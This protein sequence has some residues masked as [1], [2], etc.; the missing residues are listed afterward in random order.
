M[1]RTSVQSSV[2]CAKHHSAVGWSGGGEPLAYSIE[3]AAATVG[4]SRTSIKQEIAAGRLR[5][6]K[7]GRRTLVRHIDLLRWL[8][9]LPEAE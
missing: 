3:N 2:W 5:A 7:M 1:A 9:G 8:D 4:L 6:R